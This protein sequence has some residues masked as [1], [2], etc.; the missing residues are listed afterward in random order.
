MI[1][2]YDCYKT[3]IKIRT[4]RILSLYSE[5]DLGGWK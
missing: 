4:R 3:I 1:N 2:L 5:L